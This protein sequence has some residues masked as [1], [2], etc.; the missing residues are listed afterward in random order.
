MVIFI[1][2]FSLLKATF[3]LS[4]QDIYVLRLWK[5]CYSTSELQPIGA[6]FPFRSIFWKVLQ[7]DTSMVTSKK[8]S[9]LYTLTKNKFKSF[10]GNFFPGDFCLLVIFFSNFT[11]S[12]VPPPYLQRLRPKKMGTARRKTHLCPTRL[13]VH[14]RMN[15]NG[16]LL[17]YDLLSWNR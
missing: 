13:H 6:L 11:P 2:I 12:L 10:F 15:A 8:Y 17:P 7:T 3:Y 1:Y 4:F 14:Q 5:G 9:E 16:F